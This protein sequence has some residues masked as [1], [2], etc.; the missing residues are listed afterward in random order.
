MRRNQ[1]KKG[2]KL[3]HNALSIVVKSML[4]RKF[5]NISIA[6]SLIV[7]K[8]QKHNVYIPKLLFIK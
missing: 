8:M 7:K 4:I 5:S 2:E 6:I 1:V 3:L